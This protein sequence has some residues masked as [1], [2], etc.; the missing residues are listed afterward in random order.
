MKSLITNIK[1]FLILFFFLTNAYSN[2]KIVYIDMNAVINNSKAG[3]SINNQM[4][5]LIDKNN[6]E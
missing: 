2:E 4:K 6:K 1:S 5:K 3:I